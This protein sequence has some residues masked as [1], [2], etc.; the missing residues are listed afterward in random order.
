M[1]VAA[2]FVPAAVNAWEQRGEIMFKIAV[3]GM[4]TAA[5]LR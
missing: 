5:G 2:G 1:S 4:D 3:L